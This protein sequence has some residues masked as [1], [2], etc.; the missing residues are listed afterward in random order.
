MADLHKIGLKIWESLT[1]KLP[2]K[3]GS[4][5]LTPLHPPPPQKSI[6]YFTVCEWSL[7]C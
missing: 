4:M 5:S 7:T 3:G 1:P 2:S 6:Y